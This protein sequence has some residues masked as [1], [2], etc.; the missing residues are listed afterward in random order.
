MLILQ[1]ERW[2]MRDK[3]IYA[4]KCLSKAN[5]YLSFFCCFYYVYCVDSCDRNWEGKRVAKK[6]RESPCD[7]DQP[8]EWRHLFATTALCCDMTSLHLSPLF[9]LLFSLFFLFSSLTFLLSF[10]FSLLS[11]NWL[12]ALIMHISYYHHYYFLLFSTTYSAENCSKRLL[13]RPWNR[14]ERVCQCSAIIRVWEKALFRG[15]GTA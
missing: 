3:A 12:C 2:K 13:Y 15:A 1:T 4:I 9:S 8:G 6:S 7:W 14:E 5:I 11:S 10:L